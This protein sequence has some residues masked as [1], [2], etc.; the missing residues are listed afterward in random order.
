MS[1]VMQPQRRALRADLLDFVAEPQAL[2]THS[3]AVRFRPGHWLLIEGGR[4]HSVQARA[5]D[6]AEWWLEDHS[7]HL[8]MPGFIDTHVHS[9]QLPVMASWGTELLDWLANYTFPAEAQQA[10]STLAQVSAQGFVQQ[11][12]AHGTTAALVFPT[13]HKASCEALFQVAHARQMRL[14]AG[15]V[16][17]DRHAPAELCETLEAAQRDC[18]ELIHRWH[19]HGRL[20]YAV[21]PRF[22]PTSSDAQLQLAGELLAA[23]P[24]LYMQTHVAENRDEVAWVRELFPAARSYLD[25]YA[26]HG[27]LNE[28]SVLAHG[29]WLDDA[30]WAALRDSG[31]Q[32]AHSPSS[33][34]FLGSGLFDWQRARAEGVGV[35]LAS[36]VGGG[37]SLSMQRTLAAAY[38]VQALQGVRLT[39]WQLLHAATRGAAQGLGLAHEIGTL[40]P[41]TV[42]DVCLWRWATSAVA[43]QRQQRA[44]NLHEKLFAWLML[45]DERDL[46]QTY[47][48]GRAQNNTVPNAVHDK[49]KPHAQT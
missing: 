37:L 23:T 8:L 21:T 47:V 44:Q 34:L 42:A 5:P 17:M 29:I 27:L 49:E 22:A 31:A 35:S 36:D 40:E 3:A 4:I 32:V 14:V 26:R 48:A 30:D 2:A 10:D 13:V 1:A 20:A 41:G 9:P 12:L 15:K 38:Q 18:S 6:S 19:G 24:G 11:L 28:R 39:A 25:V 45:G 7:G 16:M 33:N 43:A 46:L